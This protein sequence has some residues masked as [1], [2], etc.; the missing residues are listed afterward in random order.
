MI[1]WCTLMPD[2][3]VGGQ[4]IGF[5]S[6]FHFS[7]R[8]REVSKTSTLLFMVVE[9]GGGTGLAL[10]W[11]HFNLDLVWLE[12]YFAWKQDRDAN[13]MW[14]VARGYHWHLSSFCHGLPCK[15]S[16]NVLF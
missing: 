10:V 9:G 11:V 12:F 4:R 3:V 6:C 2:R 1:R 15:A 13:T 7:P 8:S 5:N 14:A 16:L